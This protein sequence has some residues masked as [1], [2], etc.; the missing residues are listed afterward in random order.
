MNQDVNSVYAPEVAFSV[1]P[2]IFVL[3]IEVFD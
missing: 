1:G 3:I 2:K